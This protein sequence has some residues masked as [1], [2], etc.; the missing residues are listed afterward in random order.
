MAGGTAP[1]I[2]VHDLE[3]ARAA[4]A[5][6]GSKRLILLSPPGA[7][8]LQGPHWWLRLLARLRDEFPHADIVGAL[9]CADCPGWALAALRSGVERIVLSGDGPAHWAVRQAAEQKGAWGEGRWGCDT[10]DLLGARD[11]G[12]TCQEFLQR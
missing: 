11:P 12:K 6:A 1:V 3:H 4:V 10:L 7:A 8:G 5:A 2:L 9:D